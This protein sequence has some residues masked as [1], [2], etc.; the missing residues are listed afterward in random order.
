MAIIY[1][2][3]RRSG[4]V[5]DKGLGFIHIYYG[6]GVR[7]TS[8]AIGLAARAAGNDL[9]VDFVQFMKSGDSGEVATMKRIPNIRYWCPGQHPFIM[10]RGA[11]AVHYEHAEKAL[12]HALEAVERGTHLLVCD[13]ILDTIIFELLQKDRVRDLMERCKKKTELVMTG[14]YAPPEFVEFADYVTEF[15]QVKHAYY[16]G[17]RARKGIEY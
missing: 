8:A 10:S 1:Y 11:E 17:A 7:K 16:K 13:E 5:E 2:Y 9:Q 3:G 12:K 15:T 6:Q 4:L 14:R